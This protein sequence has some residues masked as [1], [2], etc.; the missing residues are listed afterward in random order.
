MIGIRNEPRPS[1][2]VYSLRMKSSLLLLLV[3]GL[4]S[5]SAARPQ[6]SADSRARL[7]V[8]LRDVSGAPIPGTVFV[9]T[10][11]GTKGSYQQLKIVTDN[12]GVA[13]TVLPD[14][15]YDLLISAPAFLPISKRVEFDKAHRHFKFKMKAASDCCV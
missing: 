5:I 9:I 8:E 14:G 2:G 15:S 6:S 12:S 7:E 3:I 4:V 1:G 13:S 10:Q 11:S